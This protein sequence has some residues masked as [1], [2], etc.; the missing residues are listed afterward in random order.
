MAQHMHHVWK[1]SVFQHG[2]ICVSIETFPMLEE[3]WPKNVATAMD[4][5]EYHD[6]PLPLHNVLTN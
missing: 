6:L 3:V 1:H 4:D 5:T 2:A